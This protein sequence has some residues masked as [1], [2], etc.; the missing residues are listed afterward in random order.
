MAED[1]RARVT[2]ECHVCAA[3]AW[4]V[5]RRSPFLIGGQGGPVTSSHDL[6]QSMPRSLPRS[7][8]AEPR[9]SMWQAEVVL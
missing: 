5:G 9:L 4:V 1:G 7:T 2:Q 6:Q 3:A 8:G